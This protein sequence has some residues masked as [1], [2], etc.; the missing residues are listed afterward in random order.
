[1]NPILRLCISRLV[2]LPL[3]VGVI[4]TLTLILAW[5]VPGDPL[6]GPEARRP[7]AE[8]RQQMRAQ[9]NLDSFGSFYRSYLASASGWNWLDARVGITQQGQERSQE[10]SRQDDAARTNVLPV[11]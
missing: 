4:Y 2:Q 1:V 8:V 11:P 7:P 5:A 9:Y 3:I 10:W 6:E